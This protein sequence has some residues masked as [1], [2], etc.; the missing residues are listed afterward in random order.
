MTVA[1]ACVLTACSTPVDMASSGRNAAISAPTSAPTATSGSSEPSGGESVA[2]SGQQA[3]LRA[4]QTA[5]SQLAGST[6]VTIAREGSDR[7]WEVQVVTRDGQ[8]YELE[9]S[10]D[11]RRVQQGPRLR[12]KDPAGQ[13][14]Q[15][16]LGQ[17]AKLDYRAAAPKIGAT[18]E[19]TIT[20]L[21]LDTE[22]GKTVWE[23]HV[24]DRAGTKRVVIIDAVTGQL[25]PTGGETGTTSPRPSPS[26]SHRPPHHSA[27]RPSPSTSHRPPHHSA[28]RPSPSTSHH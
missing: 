1:S 6:V 28:P 16:A 13:A 14:R 22:R 18:V 2:L 10:A 12:D 9:I 17:A 21:E 15:R 8:K 27:P 5:L 23:A 3:L 19:G 20:E 11:G 25:R 7:R 24:L 4:G 26:A